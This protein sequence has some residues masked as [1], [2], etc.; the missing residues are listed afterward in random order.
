MNQASLAHE[1]GAATIH[2]DPCVR[3]R[4]A[5]DRMLPSAYP[6]SGPRDRNP[7]G[8][9]SGTINQGSARGRHELGAPRPPRNKREALG[10]KALRRRARM[11][12]Y[13]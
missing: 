10:G 7:E 6:D 4:T 13:E 8:D 1:I 9:H 3:I 12:G 2:T 11:A 5:R